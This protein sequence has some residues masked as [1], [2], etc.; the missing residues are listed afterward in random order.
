MYC[1]CFQTFRG[2]L[3]RLVI[4]QVLHKYN[5]N[6]LK[7][8]EITNREI[9]ASVSLM[10]LSPAGFHSA[11]EVTRE[12]P[13]WENK[14][15][16]WQYTESSWRFENSSKQTICLQTDTSRGQ[17][18]NQWTGA[19]CQKSSS[20]QTLLSILRQGGFCSCVWEREIKMCAWCMLWDPKAEEITQTECDRS[21]PGDRNKQHKHTESPHFM[22]QR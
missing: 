10:S 11:A 7:Y 17:R 14:Q 9:T 20:L 6:H 16:S 12:E 13:W 18:E 3:R 8:L 19:M 21:D 5:F 22:S 2:G 4:I 1:N 15:S